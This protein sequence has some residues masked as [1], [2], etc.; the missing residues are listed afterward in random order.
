M[1]K[2]TKN[3]KAIALSYDPEGKAPKVV[4]S[5]NAEVA[6]RIIEQAQL[7]NVPVHRDDK[8]A[9]TLSKLEIGELIPQEL[10]E[11]VAN[12]LVFVDSVD[13]VR[14]KIAEYEATKR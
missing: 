13:K 9:E 7:N 3:K 4:A 5:G 12:I 11:I 2:D 14:A 8:L 10:Y 1:D 6:E